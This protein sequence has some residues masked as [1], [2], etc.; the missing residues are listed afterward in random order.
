MLKA[1]VNGSPVLL[2]RPLAP[3]TPPAAPTE[4]S[5]TVLLSLAACGTLKNEEPFLSFPHPS[6]L[7]LGEN[8]THEHF[9]ECT[10][11]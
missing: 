11:A 8:A 3:Q 4:G 6:S 9:V 1:A 7:P 10:A 5:L 2:P